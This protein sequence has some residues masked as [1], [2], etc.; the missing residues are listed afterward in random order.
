[1]FPTVAML[2]PEPASKSGC[3]IHIERFGPRPCREVHATLMVAHIHHSL[4]MDEARAAPE[5]AIAR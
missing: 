5:C 2:E 3:V 1:M 4:G